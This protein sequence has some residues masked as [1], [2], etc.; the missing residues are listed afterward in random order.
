[1]TIRGTCGADPPGPRISLDSPVRTVVAPI[2][3]PLATRQDPINRLRIR[4]PGV[5]VVLT[6]GLGE[7]LEMKAVIGLGLLGSHRTGPTGK[8]SRES[9]GPSY[10]L[11]LL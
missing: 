4:L 7:L 9:A 3:K 8:V 5:G 2:S 6:R 11:L 10:L 1:M